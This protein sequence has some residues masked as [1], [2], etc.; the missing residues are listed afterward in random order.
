MEVAAR[1]PKEMQGILACCSPV[2]PLVKANLL[3]L[4]K[5][6]LKALE[7]PFEEV[8]ISFF[9]IILRY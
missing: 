2:P 1:L 7:R 8:C 6:V 3:E 5:I 4:H 9:F